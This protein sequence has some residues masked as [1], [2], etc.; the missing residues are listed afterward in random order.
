MSLRGGKGLKRSGVIL[1]GPPGCGK[2][3]T[4]KGF[5][6]FKE[7]LLINFYSIICYLFINAK[8]SGLSHIVAPVIFFKMRY[9]FIPSR[10]LLILWVLLIL[11]IK[12]ILKSDHFIDNNFIFFSPICNSSCCKRIQ[13]DVPKCERT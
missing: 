7:K 5:F 9:Y 3:L 12:R 11:G 13:S 8:I 10:I 2:T 6:F 1:Y 4:A